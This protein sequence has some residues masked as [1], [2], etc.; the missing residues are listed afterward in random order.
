MTFA[1]AAVKALVER[2]GKIL[3]LRQKTKE[4]NYWDLPGGRIEGNENPEQALEREVMEETGLSVKVEELIGYYYFFRITDGFELVA[5]VFKCSEK[6]E[7]KVI[8]KSEHDPITEWKWVTKQE[9]GKLK[10]AHPSA[11]E[12]LSKV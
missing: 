5:L 4:F 6:E 3:A 2:D 10:F 7:R 1:Q 9:L 12:L 11:N 8:E